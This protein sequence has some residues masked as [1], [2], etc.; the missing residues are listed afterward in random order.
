METDHE[1]QS[2][3]HNLE[4][5]RQGR[6]TFTELV[7]RTKPH[8]DRLVGMILRRWRIPTWAVDHEDLQQEMLLALWKS[9][10]EWDPDHP[11]QVSLKSFVIFNGVDKA[12]KHG[13]TARK[14][15]RR[16]DKAPS[17]IMTP[18]SSLHREGE[19][20]VD[21]A[22]LVSVA[23]DQDQRLEVMRIFK[24]VPQDLHTPLQ[25]YLAE[26]TISG[27]AW[28][29]LD[30]VPASRQLGLTTHR[31]ASQAVEDAVGPFV[32]DS[33]WALLEDQKRREALGV[34][35]LSEARRAI[36]AL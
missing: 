32:D 1:R 11:K 7:K 4:E 29:L 20:P 26:G 13:H 17:R 31:E 34:T 36:L 2:L 10:K 18:V 35:T 25:V 9:L 14:A 19:D 21:V 30:D 8:W 27:A 12:K 6:I 24:Q 5:C 15:L 16:D 28:V 33:A 3:A 23:A 22:E